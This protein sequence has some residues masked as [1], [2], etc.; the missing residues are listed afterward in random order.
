MKRR[1]AEPSGG[2]RWPKTESFL[3]LVQ[4]LPVENFELISRVKKTGGLGILNVGK[5]LEAE[6]EKREREK[7]GRFRLI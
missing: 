2:V 3:V 1:R 7:G 5:M 6:S 4:F